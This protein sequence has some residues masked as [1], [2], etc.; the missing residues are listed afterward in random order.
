MRRDPLP[1]SVIRPYKYEFRACAMYTHGMGS[2]CLAGS[3]PARLTKTRGLLKRQ[4][5]SASGD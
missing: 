5:E 2:F 3:R 4:K 1:V